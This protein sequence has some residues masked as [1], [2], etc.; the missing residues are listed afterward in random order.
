MISYKRCQY[1]DPNGREC[2]TY[3]GSKDDEGDQKLC[4]LHSG[5][6]G[7]RTAVIS[8][9]V[10]VDYVNLMQESAIEARALIVPDAPLNLDQ[11]DAH[12]AALEAEIEKFKSRASAARGVRSEHI[13]KLTEEERRELRKIKVPPQVKGNGKSRD[14]KSV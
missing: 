4:P 3:F 7:P 6:L 10:K 14:P 13:Q 12:I 5:I 11:L 8:E 9:T 2:N 1:T